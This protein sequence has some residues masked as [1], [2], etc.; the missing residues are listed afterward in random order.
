MNKLIIDGVEYNLSDSLVAELKEEIAINDAVRRNRTVFDRSVG[1]KYFFMNMTGEI[2]TYTDVGD[3]TDDA[4]YA[5]A[6]YCRSEE[7]M[8]QRALHETLNRLLWRYSEMHG[9]DAPWRRDGQVRHFFICV[10]DDSKIMVDWAYEYKTP[11]VV[12]FANEGAA[13]GAIEDVVKP[14]IAEHPEFK[15]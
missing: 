11:G 15:W 8:K 3:K 2:G 5:T 9:G 1:R 4:L 13:N 6:N 7:M 10:Q 14:F 12:Y